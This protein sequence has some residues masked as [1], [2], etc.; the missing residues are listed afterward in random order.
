[1][2]IIILSYTLM[3]ILNKICKNT[4]R[5]LLI[6][7]THLGYL[8]N[9]LIRENDSFNLL[10]EAL[11]IGKNYKCDFV[12]HGGDLFE[13]NK[14]SKNTM[15]KTIDLLRKYI[16]GKKRIM[17]QVLSHDKKVFVSGN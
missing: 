13:D 7:D 16:M 5:L 3:V 2:G 17:F 12:L 4:I 1:M 6:T 15:A 14:P 11:K 9:D 8:E 10:E